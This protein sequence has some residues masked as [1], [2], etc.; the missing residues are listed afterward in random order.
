LIQVAI[1]YSIGLM[2]GLPMTIHIVVS[3]P[4]LLIIALLFIASGLPIG[5]LLKDQQVGPIASILIQI[6]AFLSG[7]WFSLDLVGGLF[8]TIGYILPFAHAVDL[9]R[10][11]LQ[12]NYA[13][14]SIPFL[15]VCIYTLIA[16]C[17]AIIVF[18]RNMKF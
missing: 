2:M 8:K 10:N 9:I 17:L 6:V 13:Q 16:L 4:I 1:L 18:K 7:M 14:I 5:S 12:G 15:I 3:I 11:V